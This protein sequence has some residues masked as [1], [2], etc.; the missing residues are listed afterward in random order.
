MANINFGFR[1]LRTLGELAIGAEPPLSR[2]AV[3]AFPKLGKLGILGSIPGAA[4][5]TSGAFAAAKIAIQARESAVSFSSSLTDAAK[6]FEA[7]G[8][9]LQKGNTSMQDVALLPTAVVADGTFPSADDLVQGFGMKAGGISPAGVTAFATKLRHRQAR[10]AAMAGQFASIASAAVAV[11]VIIRENRNRIPNPQK[12]DID[13]PSGARLQQGG[14]AA[15]LDRMLGDKRKLLA[16][17]IAVGSGAASFWTRH[18]TSKL[19]PLKSFM[20]LPGFHRGLN[21]VFADKQSSASAGWS[22]PEPPYAAQYPFNHVRQTE[23]GHIEEWDDTPGA[24]R[25]HLCHRS[26]SFVEMHPDG[27][28]VYKCMSHGYQITAGDHNVRVDGTCNISV[29]G[30]A[31]IHV[32]GEVHLESDESIKIQTKKD[33]NVE[34]TNIN[35]R[36]KEKATLDGKLIDLRYAKLP[37]VPVMTMQ[38][39]AVRFVMSEYERDYPLAALRTKSQ[40]RLTQ[41]QLG[42]N[43]ALLAAATPLTV[44]ASAFAGAN[45]LKIL[46]GLK[47]VKNTTRTPPTD[48]A[49][50]LPEYDPANPTKLSKPRENPLGNPLIYHATTQAALDYRELLFDTPE[51][52]QD[53]VQYQA[54]MDTRKALKDIPET[55][56]PA[57][58]GNRTTPTSVHTVPENLPLVEYLTRADYY[59]KFVKTPPGPVPKSTILGGTNFTVGMLADSYSQPDV[60]IFVDKKEPPIDETAGYVEPFIEWTGGLY[61]Y[62][63]TRRGGDRPNPRDSEF[64]LSEVVWHRGADVSDWEVNSTITEVNIT[65]TEVAIYHTAAMD[66]V[67]GFWPVSRSVFADGAPIE[68]NPW[69]FAFV[70]GQ[71]HGATFEYLRPGRQVMH[72]KAWEFGEHQIQRYP[73]DISWMPRGGDRVGFMMSTIARTGLRASRNYRTQVFMTTWPHMDGGEPTTPPEDEFDLSQVTW[74]H[75]DISGWAQTSTVTNVQISSRDICVK[76]TMAGKW[77]VFVNNGTAAEGNPWVFAQIGGQWYGATYEWLRPGQE[78]K[79]V[80]QTNI[81]PHTKQSPLS[82]WVPQSGE[83][84]GFAMATRSRDNKRTSNERTNVVLVTWP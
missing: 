56:G 50:E 35:L 15:Q 30:N 2:D 57:L 12:D 43:S 82:S 44:T 72:V 81:G 31:T 17:G 33:F 47:F 64:N 37:G 5:M 21:M 7:A 11:G 68:G 71:W 60:T 8:R 80:T 28:V 61:D 58:E 79:G 13:R 27:K 42:I 49:P 46:A 26:G 40:H 75:A 66:G 45:A 73:L 69:I 65:P 24:E 1:D 77:P 34:A 59:G 38:G 19:A 41:T 39:P 74:L 10:I 76:H 6:S 18:L 78:C 84:V 4:A 55:V 25:I 63:S 23:S 51:E 48:Y 53:A 54:H 3:P 32:Q 52:V 62:H 14:A 22:E 16:V 67:G 29:G 9:A 83:T 36:A 20:K 70:D